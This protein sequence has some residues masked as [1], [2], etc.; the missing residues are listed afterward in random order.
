MDDQPLTGNTDDD[1]YVFWYRTPATEAPAA[2]AALLGSW[3][4]AGV[5]LRQGTP[6]EVATRA[7]DGAVTVEQVAPPVT[8]EDA[9]KLLGSHGAKA[10]LQSVHGQAD[11]YVAGATVRA[12]VQFEYAGDDELDPPR[13][14]PRRPHMIGVLL[15]P[16]EWRDAPAGGD[17]S[18]RATAAEDA[19]A[20]RY[21]LPIA[22]KSEPLTGLSGPEH[23][24]VR[25]RLNADALARPIPPRLSDLSRFATY[26]SPAQVAAV[27][28]EHFD[29]LRNV[30]EWVHDKQPRLAPYCRKTD[31]GGVPIARWPGALDREPKF[32]AI[33]PP[34][35]RE[36]FD[37]V[38]RALL[39]GEG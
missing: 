28:A 15:M 19:L 39:G 7:A 18:E 5:A 14:D 17:A 38:R 27:G 8:R 25:W 13:V 1:T 22:G 24:S 36:A 9:G 3:V 32:V 34:R 33:L 6:L 10:R 2:F 30:F 20:D 31:A 37:A 26:L 35:D 29:R 12:R 16:R 4:E 11:L 23:D 21:L